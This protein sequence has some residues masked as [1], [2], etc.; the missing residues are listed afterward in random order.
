[1]GCR[2]KVISGCLEDFEESGSFSKTVSAGDN[3]HLGIPLFWAVE[4]YESDA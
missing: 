4:G 1:M 3:Q 2:V